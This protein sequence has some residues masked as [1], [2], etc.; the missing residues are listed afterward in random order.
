M[1][2]YKNT[3]TVF[4]SPSGIMSLA[5]IVLPAAGWTADSHGRCTVGD[6]GEPFFLPIFWRWRSWAST[7]ESGTDSLVLGASGQS[8]GEPSSYSGHMCYQFFMMDSSV[9][10]GCC[11]WQSMSPMPPNP[12]CC[13]TPGDMQLNQGIVS[14][15][16][17][18]PLR[19][20]TNDNHKWWVACDKDAM[21]MVIRYD[22]G[23]AGV[24]PFYYQP[25]YV[26]LLD[27]FHDG[28]DDPNPQFLTGGLDA[29]V[30]YCACDHERWPFT[31]TF[32][33]QYSCPKNIWMRDMTGCCW[34]GYHRKTW[35]YPCSWD[36]PSS[37][38]SYMSITGTN[39]FRKCQPWL[40]GGGRT[41]YP[42]AVGDSDDGSVS[43][44]AKQGMR[45]TMKHIWHVSRRA[46]APE[47]IVNING[48]DYIVFPRV[49][50]S[51]VG[52]S[53]GD[54]WLAMRWYT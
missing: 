33:L 13:I 8:P 20:N 38:F 27:S 23:G 36:P 32:A 19:P 29:N 7:G 25:V 12:A 40:K 17:G 30:N 45:G 16:P 42:I 22:A 51:Y 18:V 5:N 15:W 52:A 31:S 4:P 43:G 48:N 34:C 21:A 11:L 26:G 47:D 2:F 1:A 10:S 41:L 53:D 24:G 49:D 54:Y 3:G 37:N 6:T 14:G 44:I 28:T 46:L 50:D 39:T 9:P 35:F